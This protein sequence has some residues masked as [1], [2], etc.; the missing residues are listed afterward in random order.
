[1]S[2]ILGEARI[3]PLMNIQIPIT[4]QPADNLVNYIASILA[5]ISNSL[6]RLLAVRTCIGLISTSLQLLSSTSFF[7]Q[8]F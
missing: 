3:D 1:M 8:L 2:H 5:L 7:V 6:L 4:S